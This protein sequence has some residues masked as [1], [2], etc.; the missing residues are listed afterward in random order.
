LSF[1]KHFYLQR[2]DSRW[3]HSFPAGNV[4]PWRG[5]KWQAG[6]CLSLI[7]VCFE[8]P[9]TASWCSWLPR[10]DNLVFR[11]TPQ[12]TARCALESPHQSA[13]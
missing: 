1:Y 9:A 12:H 7:A 2:Q 11:S 5:W 13:G 4:R 10:S 6:N 8:R 3:R